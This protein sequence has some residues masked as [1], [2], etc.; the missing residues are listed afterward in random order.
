MQTAPQ[1]AAAALRDAIISGELQGGD[2]ILEQEWSTTLGI[3]QPTLREAMRELEHQGLL[4]KL[5]QRGT[6]VTQ[7]SPDDYRQ[8][9]EVRIP[10]EVMAIERAAARMTPELAA[11]LTEIVE[12]M[13]GTENDTDVRRFHD[14][15]V[16][17]HRRI[18]E[19]AGNPYLR[20]LLEAITFRLFVFSI[21]GRWHDNPDKIDERRAAVQQHVGIVEGIKSGDP[22]IAR[23][24]YIAQTVG[25][26]NQQYHLSLDEHDLLRGADTAS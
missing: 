6:Y 15:D 9:M 7:L 22:A 8:I 4:H 21:V 5:P 10:L 18:W 20:D 23:R 26:W 12:T 19:A 25:Y 24:A 2:R 3:G 13:A 1:A 14:C 17:F 11:D 16:M